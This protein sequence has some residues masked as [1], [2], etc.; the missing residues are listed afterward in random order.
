M[1]D[2]LE[3]SGGLGWG[4]NSIKISFRKLDWAAAPNALDDPK[5]KELAEKYNKSPAQVR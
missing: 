3:A 4:Y 1:I 5:V 2:G